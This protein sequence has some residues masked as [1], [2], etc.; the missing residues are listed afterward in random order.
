M[1]L[2][3][4]LWGEYRTKVKILDQNRSIFLKHTTI[5]ETYTFH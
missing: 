1:Q 5:C 3:I 4:L 2:L